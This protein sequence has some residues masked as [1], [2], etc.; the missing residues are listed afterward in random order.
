MPGVLYNARSSIQYPE[1]SIQCSE[2]YAMPGDLYTMPGVLY[3]ARRFLLKIFKST[4]CS[5]LGPLR[6]IEAR[7]FDG[8]DILGTPRLDF[9]KKK[10]FSL[11]SPFNDCFSQFQDVLRFQNILWFVKSN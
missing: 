9:R 8:V 4:F 2:F 10:H 6:A 5:P 11:N 3:N 7:F 1:I